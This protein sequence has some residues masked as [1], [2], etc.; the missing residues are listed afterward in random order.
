M[1]Y[2]IMKA[3]Q[4]IFQASYCAISSNISYT[5]FFPLYFLSIFYLNKL[6]IDNI[7]CS[8]HHLKFIFF[9]LNYFVKVT[10][11]YKGG[12]L[13]SMLKS[14]FFFFPLQW[15]KISFNRNPF[16]K[17]AMALADLEGSLLFNIFKSKRLKRMVSLSL[18]LSVYVSSQVHFIRESSNSVRYT[19]N[20]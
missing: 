12:W 20:V 19:M 10:M 2:L 8:L 18:S 4:W 11:A 13:S 7:N 9:K 3:L 6:N 14:L 1:I 5:F 17:L 15:K 16:S